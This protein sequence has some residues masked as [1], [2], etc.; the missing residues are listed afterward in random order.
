MS[1][2]Q[3]AHDPMKCVCEVNLGERNNHTLTANSI[4]ITC[5]ERRKLMSITQDEMFK[6]DGDNLTKKRLILRSF[7]FPKRCKEFH[8]YF[9]T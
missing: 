6:G 5:L 3:R 4:I 8:E 1:T 7:E 9:P 2:F